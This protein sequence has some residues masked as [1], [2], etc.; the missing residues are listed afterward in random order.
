M[1]TLHERIAKRLGWTV[2]QTQSFSLQSL[3]ELV[4]GY[5][6]LEAE[7]TELIR[8]GRVVVGESKRGA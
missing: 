8:S 4:R 2:E 1:T 7:I 6:K 5:P 3:R